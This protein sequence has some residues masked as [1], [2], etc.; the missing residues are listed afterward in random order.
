RAGLRRPV[1]QCGSL[2]DVARRHRKRANEG[3]GTWRQAYEDAAG[4]SRRESTTESARGAG[5]ITSGRV[6]CNGVNDC[7]VAAAG[8]LLCILALSLHGSTR[9]FGGLGALGSLRRGHFRLT[10]RPP[11]PACT[12]ASWR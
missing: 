5:Q 4:T 2:H 9:I 6:A 1:A 12:H 10:F 7:Y 3:I 11:L 8:N